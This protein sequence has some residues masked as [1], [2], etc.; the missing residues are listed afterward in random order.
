MSGLLYEHVV[1]SDTATLNSLIRLSELRRTSR[2]EEY[3]K[4]LK[5][6]IDSLKQPGARLLRQP[7]FEWSELGLES[8]CFRFELHRALMGVYGKL[9]EQAERLV[10]DKSYAEA[11]GVYKKATV[12]A[13]E[14]ASNLAQWTATSMELK[15]APPFDVH[16]LLAMTAAARSRMH[17]CSF[18]EKYENADSWKCGVVKPDMR[19]ALEACRQSCRFATLSSLLWAR[20]DD[21]QPGRV[22]TRPDAHELG[23]QSYYHFASAFCASNFQTRLNHA[24]RCQG[25]FD[26]MREVVELNEKLYYQTPE[27]AEVPAPATVLEVC[28]FK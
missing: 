26:C 17:K 3:A 2:L 27:D 10:C 7:M 19:E 20:P 14:C 21:K 22:T 28:S 6:L 16:C 9:E 13:M 11:V 18:L 25:E 1:H 15:R 23:M 8:P 5:S 12:A 24:A 4:G